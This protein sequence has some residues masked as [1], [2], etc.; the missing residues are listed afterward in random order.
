MR[1]Y[2]TELTWVVSDKDGVPKGLQE[3]WIVNGVFGDVK[4][5]LLTETALGLFA[6]R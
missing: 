6:K 5:G 1:R 3:G 2:P 4:G